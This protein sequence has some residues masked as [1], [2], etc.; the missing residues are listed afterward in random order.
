MGKFR[1]ISG[2]NNARVDK[3]I[4]EN[5]NGYSRSFAQNLIND[6]NVTVNGNIVKS[7]YKLKLDDVIDVDVPEPKKLDVLPQ[8]IDIDVVYEDDDIIIVNKPKDMVV[9][10]A[11]GNYEG[12]LVNALLA[13]CDGKLSDIN[14]VIRPGIVHRI[15]KDTTGI[16]VVAK[17]NKAHE[18]L[19]ELFRVHD[20]K[21]TYIA[22]VEG[23]I[24]KDFG[25][26]DAPIGR[27]PND[28]KKMAI[29]FKNGRNAVTHFKVLER[30]SNTVLKVEAIK[31]SILRENSDL[32]AI[33]QFLMP[34]LMSGQAT[35][36]D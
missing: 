1:L 35:I 9:H 28:R 11:V 13:H 18:K 26:I 8:D 7:N 6:G 2:V 20:I 23:V 25:K 36:A 27:H 32:N 19:S 16:L 33:R 22:I 29:N 21:R 30:F 17:N 31:S 34:M 12:T 4:S 5:L 15:D 24:S 3:Y 14:G 10:P